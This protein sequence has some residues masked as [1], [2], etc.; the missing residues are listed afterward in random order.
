M[1]KDKKHELGLNPNHYEPVSCDKEKI[2][3]K[4]KKGGHEVHIAIKAL[5]P[6][7]RQKIHQFAKGGKVSVRDS[8]FGKTIIKEDEEKPKDKEHPYGKTIMKDDNS[9]DGRAK[10]SLMKVANEYVDDRE[11]KMAEGGE[12]PP[13]DPGA[14]SK[15]EDDSFKWEAYKGTDSGGLA[16]YGAIRADYAPNRAMAEGGQVERVDKKKAQDMSKG[17]MSGGPT[18]TEG[19]DNIKKG[20]G[21]AEGGDVP[22]LLRAPEDSNFE[23]VQIDRPYD[24]MQAQAYATEREAE[25]LRASNPA[26]YSGPDDEALK[27]EALHKV[28]DAERGSK[29]SMP[30]YLKIA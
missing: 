8:I 21:F 25:H 20:L 29:M 14:P 11:K 19:F 30:S 27:A 16:G 9:K 10:A 6:Q 7:F 24:P 26:K 15:K 2:V 18:I 4:H 12:V 22:E 17:A 3:L 5:S 13:E 1:A 23:K 28:V